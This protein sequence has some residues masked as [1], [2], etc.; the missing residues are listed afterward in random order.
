MDFS[1]LTDE[2]LLELISKAMA[3]AVDRGLEKLAQAV[4]VDAQEVARIK[5]EVIE[6]E[7]QKQRVEKLERAKREAE[8][9]AKAQAAKETQSSA[10]AHKSAMMLALKAHP[11]FED[12]KDF[13]LNIWQSGNGEVRVYLQ[14]PPSGRRGH[15]WEFVYYSTGSQYNAPGTIDGLE[16]DNIAYPAMKAFFELV[17]Q[18]W[19]PGLKVAYGGVSGVEPNE[20]KLAKYRAALGLEV[21][22]V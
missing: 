19:N 21:A 11:L 22:N 7:K 1:Q 6:Q 13:S 4:Y 10:W 5:A 12:D 8:A 20:A 3:A 17:C 18:H 9:E 16:A 14:G 2:Q 15:E